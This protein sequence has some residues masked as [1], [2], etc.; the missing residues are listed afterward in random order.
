MV[1][2]VAQ[3]PAAIPAG[4]AE[5]GIK[6]G[7]QGKGDGPAGRGRDQQRRA[8]HEAAVLAGPGKNSPAHTAETAG[9]VWRAPLGNMLLKS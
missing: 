8:C 3:M 2:T 4:I 6:T 1:P 7:N 9:I 5:Q